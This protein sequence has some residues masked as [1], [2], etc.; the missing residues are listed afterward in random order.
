MPDYSI[1]I[2]NLG[3]KYIIGHETQAGYK[4]LRDTIV[5]KAGK[6]A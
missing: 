4:T 1:K 6:A 2:E 3:K 5:E